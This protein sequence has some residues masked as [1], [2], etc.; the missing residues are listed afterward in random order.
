[1]KMNS[2]TIKLGITIM[3]LFLAVLF[4]LVYTIDQMFTAFY[5]NQKQEQL[6]RFASEYSTTISSVED[7]SSYHMFVMISELTNTEMFVFNMEG[8]I[9]KST[10]ILGFKEGAQVPEDIYKPIAKNETVGFEYNGTRSQ[11]YFLSGKPII[12][13]KEVAGGLVVVSSMAE[14]NNSIEQV[15]L[16]L[17]ISVM[18]ALFMAIGFTFFVSRKLSYPLLQ[19]ERATREIAKGKLKTKLLFSTKDEVGSLAHA[20]T[21]LGRELEEYRTNRREFFANISHELRTPISYIKGY[22]EVLRDGL[23]HNEKE[24]EQYLSIITEESRRLT[25]LINDLFELAKMEEGKLELNYEWFDLGDV[26]TS[27]VKKVSLKA[28]EKKMDIRIDTSRDYPVLYT[29]GVR[30]E[31]ILINLIE[32]AIRY[33]NPESRVDIYTKVHKQSVEIFLHDYG[34]GIPEEDAPF[35]FERFYRVD[36]SRSRASGGTGLGL[37]IVKNLVELL[38]GKID[39]RSISGEGTTFIL[40][41]PANEEVSK[42][43]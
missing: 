3:V 24:R 2:I 18:G 21:D 36:K 40:S 28:A 10:G 15:R 5:V 31:Q 7:T 4:P 32:N 17:M 13:N 42:D 22:S 29:D 33:S 20:I 38:G 26:L 16:W 25:M 34:M 39:F 37:A 6:E 43:K 8:N 12:V 11:D 19:M 9:L 23:V 14:V 35:V 30:L 1:M 27:S 41:L